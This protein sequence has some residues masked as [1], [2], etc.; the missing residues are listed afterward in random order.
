MRRIIALIGV[1]AAVIAA[2]LIY[3]PSSDDAQATKEQQAEV[4][5]GIEAVK[6]L[7]SK[8]VADIEKKITPKASS[9]PTKSASPKA[10]KAVKESD[11]T[12]KERFAS[13]NAIVLG[14]SQAKSLS[15]YEILNEANVAAKISQR[16]K[17]SDEQIDKAINANASIVF[18]TYGINDMG[19]YANGKLYAEEYAKKLERLKTSLPNAKIYVTSIFPASDAV[20]ASNPSLSPDVLKDYNTAL[21]SKAESMGVT[22]IDCSGIVEAKYYEPD[23]QHFKYTMY[24]KWAKLMADSAGL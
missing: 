10:D 17:N 22:Y 14:D 9:A 2:V 11:K 20:A 1:A 23:G 6:A 15:E 7:E 5:M 16:V 24:V 19:M 4:Q 21:K 12:P 8:N 18:M 3:M 13:A